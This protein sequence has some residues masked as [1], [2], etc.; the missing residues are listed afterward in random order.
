VPQKLKRIRKEINLMTQTTN[1]DAPNSLA[2]PGEIAAMLRVP[3]KTIY[4][5]V[6]RNE[7]PFIR[8]GRHLRFV[9]EKVIAFFS[10]QTRQA[11]ASCT[12]PASL[13]KHHETLR[14]LKIRDV[15]SAP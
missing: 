13:L 6:G 3:E 5:W 11:R 15:N 14:S 12:V 1:I 4:Y 7:I 2:T 10:E 8:V 9:P